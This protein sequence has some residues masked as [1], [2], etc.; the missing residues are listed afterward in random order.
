MPFFSHRRPDGIEE[1]ACHAPHEPFVISP[2]KK[3]GKVCE[4][5]QSLG[6]LIRKK[7]KVLL[8]YGVRPDTTRQ[9]Q[10]LTPV[11]ENRDLREGFHQLV[12]RHGVCFGSF[13][14]FPRQTGITTRGKKI[15]D[16]VCVFDGVSGCGL[17]LI[18]LF[19]KWIEEA[20]S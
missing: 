1:V 2:V 12:Y 3:H 18:N 10:P 17:S 14:I 4:Y 13:A 15:H 19:K 11:S 5:H 20:V 8:W 6:L 7:F 9:D 16:A